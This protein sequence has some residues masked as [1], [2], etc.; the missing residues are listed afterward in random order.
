MESADRDAEI[1][2][3]SILVVDDIEL[4]RVLIR[5]MLKTGGFHNIDTAVD[6]KDALDKIKIHRPDL[7]VL[8]VMMPVMDGLE[9]TKALRAE[10]DM[11]HLPILIQTAIREPQAKRDAFKAGANDIITKPLDRQELISRA[12]VHLQNALLLR[13]LDAFHSRMQ[14]ELQEAER[15]QASILPTGEA[16][17]AVT[18]K[19]GFIVS[20]HFAPAGE[21]SGDYWTLD[22]LEN[23]SL[24]M[25]LGDEV[26][27][28]VAAALRAFS[29]HAIATPLSSLCPTGDSA[30]MLRKINQQVCSSNSEVGRFTA[31]MAVVIDAERAVVRSTGAGMR[32]G[33]L[34]HPD[35]TWD[36]IVGKG[37]PLGISEDSVWLEQEVPYKSG[38]VIVCFSDALIETGCDQNS[39]FTSDQIAEWCV[40]ALN[41]P[42]SEFASLIAQEFDTAS[43]HTATDDLLIVA[44]CI[45]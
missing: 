22:A 15:L 31:A 18:E 16:C 4:N 2:S 43:N 1:Q 45:P 17:D 38:D 32:N 10:P 36:P 25:L 26:G 13:E 29:L 9:L 39:E 6:G 21:L 24:A 44:V 34:F 40:K 33:L 27:H 19:T 35:G 3:C 30:A 42:K 28:G 23:G 8:D 14:S 5:D 7:L 20:A 37:L 12:Q 11:A 41:G